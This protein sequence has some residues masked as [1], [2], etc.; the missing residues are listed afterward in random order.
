MT[1]APKILPL[2]NDRTDSRDIL[3]RARSQATQRGLD[4]YFIVDVDSHIGDGAAW[5]EILKYVENSATFKNSITS[6]PDLFNR[7][8]ADDAAIHYTSALTI[9]PEKTQAADALQA[10]LARGAKAPPPAGSD[11]H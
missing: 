8:I 11:S 1:D 3:A 2:I 4:D 10:V 5:S 9:E 7:Q 6:I